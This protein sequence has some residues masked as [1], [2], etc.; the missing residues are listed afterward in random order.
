MKV[1][2]NITSIVIEQDENTRTYK[3]N[4]T[5][6]NNTYS[7]TCTRQHQSLFCTP[8]PI[9]TSHLLNNHD[10]V[11]PCVRKE[12]KINTTV[13]VFDPLEM[14]MLITAA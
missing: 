1:D 5:N 10:C 7:Y 6:Y 8:S 3:E 14:Q 4:V 13:H 9:N 11:E 12:I 2:R